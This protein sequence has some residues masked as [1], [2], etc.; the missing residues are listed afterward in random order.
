[1]EAALNRRSALVLFVRL[2]FKG[3]QTPL[4]VQRTRSLGVPSAL[5]LIG[6]GF[7]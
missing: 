5:M 1:M 3:T 2:G 6:S 7:S 4:H